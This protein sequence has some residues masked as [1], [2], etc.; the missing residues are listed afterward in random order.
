MWFKVDININKLINQQ[1]GN[2]IQ[3][4]DKFTDIVKDRV[5]EKTP[6]DTKDLLWSNQRSEVIINWS[7]LHSRVYNDTEYAPYVEYWVEWKFYEYHKP[8]WKTFYSWVW[9]WMYW[10][11][12]NEINNKFNSLTK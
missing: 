1:K 9:A 3:K 2:M 4:L 7:K 8:K 6:E 10:R 11:T 5:D 12:K